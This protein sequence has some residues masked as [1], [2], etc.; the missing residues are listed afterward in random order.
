MVE[1]GAQGLG[2]GSGSSFTIYNLQVTGGGLTLVA[3]AGQGG[4]QNNN[5]YSSCFDK[6]KMVGLTTSQVLTVTDSS[7]T[8]AG[9][10]VALRRYIRA[11]AVKIV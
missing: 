1:I 5:D 8:N 11:Q 3:V 10:T 9:G 4:G 7:S 2:S 6:G